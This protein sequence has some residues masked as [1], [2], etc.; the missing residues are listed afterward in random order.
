MKLILTDNEINVR[1]HHKQH[2]TIQ[3]MSEKFSQ[4]N[5]QQFKIIIPN[6]LFTIHHIPYFC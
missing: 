4:P 2:N 1:D 6:N 3:H 5:L